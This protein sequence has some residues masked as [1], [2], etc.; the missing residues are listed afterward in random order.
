[1]IFIEIDGKFTLEILLR[2]HAIERY[3]MDLFGNEIKLEGVYTSMAIVK[4]HNA[5]APVLGGMLFQGEFKGVAGIGNKVAAGFCRFPGENVF[6][7]HQKCHEKRF[8]RG[9][10]YQV[11]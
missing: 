9:P 4:R 10:G 1:M 5:A 8:K 11:P 3:R 6:S 2:R 7:I